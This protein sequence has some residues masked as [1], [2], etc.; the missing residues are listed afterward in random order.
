V[1]GDSNRVSPQ[2]GAHRQQLASEMVRVTRQSGHVIACSPN[3]WFPFDI[4]HGRKP[5]SYTPKLNPP[6]SRFLLSVADYRR[7]FRNAGCRRVNTLPVEGFWG[8]VT[9]RKSRKG[10]M[11]SLP[12]RVAFNVASQP[13]CAFLRPSPFI[14]WIAVGAQV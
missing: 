2:F 7:L 4:F 9:M 6:W 14:P 11:L 10:R 13:A 5:G 12:I 8:F 1:I 3:R